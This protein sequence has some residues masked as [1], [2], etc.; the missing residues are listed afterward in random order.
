MHI[1][2][3]EIL[4]QFAEAFTARYARLIVT[5]VNDHWVEAAAREAT[6]YGASVVGCDAEAG[7]ERH[8]TAAETPDGR[9]G[10]A[11][12]FFTFSVEQLAHAIAWRVG[13]CVLTCP[14][15]ACFNGLPDA[16]EVVPLGGDTR[17][18]ADG[19]EERGTIADCGLPIADSDKTSNPKSKIRNPKLPLWRLPVWDGEFLVDAV[20]GVG[21]GVAGGNLVLHAATPAAGLEAAERAV[22]AVE[23]LAGVIT[24]FPGG[25]CRA[26]SKVGALTREQIVATIDEAYCPTLRDRV[27]TKLVE[28]AT[29]A[30][31]IIFNGVDLAAVGK[32]MLAA[33]EAAAGEGVLAIGARSFGG[34]LGRHRI[35]LRQLFA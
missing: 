3:T 9:P 13:E 8:L 2:P 25:V 24:P 14:T 32:A 28:G 30:Y 35:G 4:D 10:V 1:G 11:L 27:Q 21:R 7:V 20:A 18:F 31:E 5:A 26:G 16:E 6:G 33:S 34:K 15:T 22:K 17:E 12:L 23:P 19:F 29:A